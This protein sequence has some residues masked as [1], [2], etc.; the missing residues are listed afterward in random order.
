MAARHSG[1]KFYRSFT[2]L[3][4]FSGRRTMVSGTRKGTGMVFLAVAIFIA[5]FGWGGKY[6]G[7]ED[8]GG[9]IQ[10]AL[11]TSFILGIISGYKARID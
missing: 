8:P 3:D 6:F 1:G 5:L 7:W 4:A 11:A 10:L 9:R 2:P